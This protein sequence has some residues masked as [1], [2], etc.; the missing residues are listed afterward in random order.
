MENITQPVIE[1]S[2]LA[3]QFRKIEREIDSELIFE[4]NQTEKTEKES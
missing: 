1:R 4:M 2:T 3:D